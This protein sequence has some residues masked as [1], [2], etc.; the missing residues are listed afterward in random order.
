MKQSERFLSPL[1]G[2]GPDILPVFLRDF[3]L[4]MDVL[5]VPTTYVF[6]DGMD[7]EH[8]SESVTAFARMTGQDALVGTVHSPAFLVEQFG[9]RMK[10]PERGVPSPEVHPFS[11]PSDLDRADTCPKGIALDAAE[12]YRITREAC[13]DLAVI[14]N[15]T[16]PLTKASVLMG[17]ELLSISVETERDFVRDVIRIGEEFTDS[18]VDIISDDIDAVFAASASDNPDLFGI[19]KVIG[20]TVPYLSDIVRMAGRKGLPVIFHP[21]GDYC[22]SN[23][24]E[25]IIGTGI[26]CF[27]FAENCDTVRIRSLIGGRCAVMGGTDIVP[28]LYSGSVDEIRSETE[29]YKEAFSGSGYIFSCSCSLQR[30]VPL[31]SIMTMMDAVR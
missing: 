19:E 6:H 29:R 30:G 3:T 13:P 4:G 12:A 20:Y 31:E 21:H 7:P 23:L 22:D 15:I 9:G 26:D 28:T 27:Q 18:F 11:S 14:G 16:G 8:S 10:Y 1:R 2:E 25:H 17:M 24:I 5:D